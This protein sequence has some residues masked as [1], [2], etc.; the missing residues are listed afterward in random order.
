[1]GVRTGIARSGRTSRMD[2]GLFRTSRSALIAL[3]MFVYRRLFGLDLA[4]SVR[5]SLSAKLDLTFPKG[6]HIGD[7]SYVA[8]GARVLS[9]DMARGLYLHTR[10][11][12]NCF[13]GGHALILPGVVIGDGCVIGAGSVVTKDV[14]ARSVA[15]GNP[16]R[17]LRSDVRVGHYGRFDDADA[18]EMRLRDSDPDASR[19][20]SADLD[21]RR[22]H[23]GDGAA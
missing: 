8:F 12:R 20:A 22:T 11:G 18:S 16:A 1:M 15:A 5:M 4:P 6:I 13:I 21:R 2:L 10:I 14:P 19:L 17:I 23:G 9:H 7:H 3:R